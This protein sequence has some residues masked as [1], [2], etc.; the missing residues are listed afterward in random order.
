LRDIAAIGDI[1][2]NLRVLATLGYFKE[3]LTTWIAS[4]APPT[5]GE[6][7]AKD[8]LRRGSIFTH[9]SN[10][11]FKGLP[12]VQKAIERGDARPPLAEGYAKL[13]ALKPGFVARFKFSHEHL[14]SNSAWTE[15][16]GQ[17]QMLLL[18]LASDVMDSEVQVV[19]YV[20]AYPFIHLLDGGAS[21]IGGRWP[22]HLETHID[23]IDTFNRIRAFERPQSRADLRI[24]QTVSEAS[25]KEAFAEIIGEPTVP[26]DWGGERSDLFSSRVEIDGRRV[27]AAF[28][29]KGPAKFHPMTLADLGKNGDQIDRLFSEPADLM[30]L[31]HCHEVTPPVRSMMRAYAQRM[32]Q[33]K[34]FCVI[35]GYDTLRILA[36]YNK[37]GL[38]G[39]LKQLATTP[40]R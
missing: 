21:V 23:L 11:Y 19:P 1:H 8:E 4:A 34:T 36:A 18:G 3:R 27:P 29:L 40:A 10:Y 13:D 7:L 20:L 31:Q 32:G 26:N 17:K 5:L 2:D 14:T 39:S 38:G 37:C 33:L 15:L 24:L 25:V 9:F 16:S 28:A 6:L 35:D 22:W 12:T 30:V